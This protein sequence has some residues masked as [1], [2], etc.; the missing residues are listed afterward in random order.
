MAAMQPENP[1]LSL[2]S[3]FKVL[4]RQKDRLAKAR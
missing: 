1:A 3:T 2:A 4:S